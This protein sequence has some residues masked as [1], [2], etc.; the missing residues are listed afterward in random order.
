[1]LL[2]KACVPMLNLF[3]MR[4]RELGVALTSSWRHPSRLRARARLCNCNPHGLVSDV[5]IGTGD[6]LPKRD[7]SCPQQ[8]SLCQ[9]IEMN[10]SF[11]PPIFSALHLW[12]WQWNQIVGCNSE[13]LPNLQSKRTLE[14]NMKS[15]FWFLVTE[16]TNWI[17]RPMSLNQ[18]VSCEDLWLYKQ[19]CK[20]LV[21]SFRMSRPD[22]FGFERRQ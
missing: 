6:C 14:T 20:E 15:S 17:T 4:I 10:K 9:C 13:R 3:A 2:S 21:L 22:G 16:D 7:I 19:P 5:E 11:S 1:M 18:F 8:Q 12:T